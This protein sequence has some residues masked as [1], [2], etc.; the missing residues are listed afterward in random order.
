MKDGRKPNDRG[1]VHRRRSIGQHGNTWQIYWANLQRNQKPYVVPAGISRILNRKAEDV[2]QPGSKHNQHMNRIFRIIIGPGLA[3]FF[4]W[5]ALR[6][7]ILEVIE[8]IHQTEISYIVLGRIRLFAGYSCR[9][10][11]WLD[12]SSMKTQSS[13]G[14][15]APAYIDSECGCK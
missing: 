12:A 8:S 9:I 10:E 11:R 5:L 7:S 3:I 2:A 1:P 4:I 6:T 13:I 15:N 14:K